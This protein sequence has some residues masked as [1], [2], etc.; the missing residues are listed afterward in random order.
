MKNR[1]QSALEFLMTYGWA[2]LAAIVVIAVLAIYFRPQQLVSSAPAVTAPFYAQ[3][4]KTNA[5]TVQLEVKNNGGVLVNIT[6]FSA[7]FTTPNTA[8]CVGLATGAN[9]A[10]GSTVILSAVN[11]TGLTVGNTY[12]ANIQINYLESGSSLVQSSTG[13]IAGSVGTS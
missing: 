1:G 7:T 12:N 4:V 5:T 8:S 11:C 10:A 9:L 13:T 6:A 3:A 2:I